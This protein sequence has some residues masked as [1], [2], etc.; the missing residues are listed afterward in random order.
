MVLA[1]CDVVELPPGPTAGGVSDFW[2]RGFGVVMGEVSCGSGLSRCH[3]FQAGLEE[4]P[5]RFGRRE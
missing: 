3:R 1:G 4:T 2:P 5:L